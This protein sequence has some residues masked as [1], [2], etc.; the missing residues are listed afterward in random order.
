VRRAAAAAIIAA[1][2]AAS[3]AAAKAPLRAGERI[4]LNTATVTELMRLPN[5][6]RK[7]AEAILARRGRKPFKRVEELAAVKGI[8]PAWIARNR[9]VLAVT[10]PAP[11]GASR[12]RRP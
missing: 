4:D 12:P 11:G 2:L 9:S 1:M 3:P 5:V 6:G 7:R 10:A 8:S